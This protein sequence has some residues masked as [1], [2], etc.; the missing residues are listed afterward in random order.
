[1]QR[2]R[3]LLTEIIDSAERII[4]LV[5]TRSADQF[6]ADRDRRDALLWNYTVLGEAIGQLS[7]EL[8]A[9][10]PN[11][12]WADPVRMR[13]RVV[14]GYWSIDLEVLVTTARLDLP[15]FLSSVRSIEV[16]PET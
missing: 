3:L 6:D 7:G 15:A 10:H 14:H 2:D 11:V 16:S 5:A 8:K 1:M 12:P 4:E 9:A 13:N